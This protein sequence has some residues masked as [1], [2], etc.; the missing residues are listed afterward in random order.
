MVDNSQDLTNYLELRDVEDEL[1]T[2]E[3][4]FGEQTRILR[5]LIEEFTKLKANSPLEWLRVVDGQLQGYSGQVQMMIKSCQ[6][7]QES[8]SVRARER[9]C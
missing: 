7:A 1:Q 2:L 3:K 6:S 9:R 8:V 4:L 5:Q